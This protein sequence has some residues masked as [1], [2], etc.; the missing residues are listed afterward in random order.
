MAAN[1]VVFLYGRLVNAGEPHKWM[2][3]RVDWRGWIIC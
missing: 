1:G 3:W 2:E